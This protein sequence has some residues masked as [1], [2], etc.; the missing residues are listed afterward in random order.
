MDWWQEELWMRGKS[1]ARA[2]EE[3]LRR[4]NGGRYDPL[5]LLLAR[6]LKLVAAELE[7]IKEFRAD[8]DAFQD[9][10]N[11]A[12]RTQVNQSRPQW[13]RGKGPSRR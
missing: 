2:R 13:R 6:R 3:A 1:L 9:E 10:Q 8:L 11:P 7:F 4:D 12:P 5:P